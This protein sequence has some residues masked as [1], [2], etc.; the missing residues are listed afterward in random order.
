MINDD[1]DDNDD[2]NRLMLM[3]ILQLSFFVF[4]LFFV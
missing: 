1:N 2:D 3:K 4:K